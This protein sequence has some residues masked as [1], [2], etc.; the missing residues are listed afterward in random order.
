MDSEEFRSDANVPIE[1]VGSPLCMS[2]MPEHISSQR[3]LMFSS[4][5]SQIT[6]VSGNEV[7]R[8]QSGFESKYGRYC[9]NPAAREHDVQILD[10]VPK[11][12][13]LSNERGEVIRSP[14]TTI[15]YLDTETPEPTVGFFTIPDYV[16]LHSGF[17][18]HTKKINMHELVPMNVIPK[19]M[20]FVEAPNHDDDLYKLGVNANVC[21][22]PVWGT[23]N[24]AF[25]ISKSLQEKFTHTSMDQLMLAIDNDHIPLNM[26]GTM[27]EYKIFPDVG[28][29]VRDDGILMALREHTVNSL[30]ADITSESLMQPSLHDSVYTA[31][32]GAE[33]LDIT[34][35]TN[36]SKMNDIRSID[37]YSQISRYQ[38]SLNAYY[39][40]II[41]CYDNYVRQGYAISSEFSNLVTQ[42]K[43]RSYAS[44]YRDLVLMNKKDTVELV[45]III[46]YAVE[47]KISRGFKL[48]S[49]EGAK[50]VVSDV[51]N[52]ED[53]PAYKSGSETHRA[54]IL[55]TGESPF[56]RLNSSQ[57]YEQFIN[58]ASD[59][60][61]QR[62]RDGVIPMHQKYDYI[63]SLIEHIRPVYAKYIREA[64]DINNESRKEFV[65][66]VEREGIYYIIP[67]F[68]ETITPDM[69]IKVSDDFDIHHMP[70]EYYQYD[71]NG[72][73]YKVDIKYNG[74]IGS[75][76]MFLLGKIPLDS[77]SCIE[78]GYVSQFNLPNKP[79]DHDTKQQSMFGWTPCRYGEEETAILVMSLGP[80]VVCRLLAM[81]SNCLPAQR[82]LKQHLLNDPHPT[83]LDKVELTDDE[84]VKQSTN[85]GL[86]NHMFAA[87]GYKLDSVGGNN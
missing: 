27:D 69:I 59:I 49:R 5:A 68:T 57:N 53:M 37:T 83:Q 9:I 46:T 84:V 15:I 14:E 20:K 71:E 26:Y 82:L 76:Y 11:F 47:N 44:D 54:D 28:E 48:T 45:Y 34:V 40:T 32:A 31:P 81:Y 12:T 33:V 79:S 25:I 78:F 42:C 35:F 36:K 61:V 10:I 7:A 80:T 75:K 22:V 39:N 43:Q 64:T 86:F 3:G 52:D 60:V 23:T 17:G 51:W 77:L 29:K 8:I 58:F 85:I 16:M 55:I 2:P 24:D 19:D 87:C 66:T 30:I 21:Y 73:R 4:N 70:L 1:V 72:E 74:L 13:R 18:Y 67:P 56:N 63:M 62:C 50:G 41:H 65:E 6:L 38:E